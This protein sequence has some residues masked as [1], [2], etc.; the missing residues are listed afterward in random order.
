MTELALRDYW[1]AAG[2]APTGV[3]AGSRDA[4]VAELRG[5]LAGYAATADRAIALNTKF[6]AL[7]ERLLASDAELRA[8]IAAQ[9]SRA[10]LAEAENVA[11]HTEVTRLGVELRQAQARPVLPTSANPEHVRRMAQV[12]WMACGTGQ[13]W[14]LMARAALDALPELMRAP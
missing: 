3:G 9:R 12:L 1:L 10:S 14:T 4:E 8:E 2:M 6:I 11:L 5:H 13:D 7:N